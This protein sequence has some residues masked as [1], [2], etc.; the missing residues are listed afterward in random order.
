MLM[1]MSQPREDWQRLADYVISARIAAGHETTRAFARA[2]GI[3]ERTLGKLE[4]AQPVGPETLAV[5]AKTVGWTPDS[6][7]RILGRGEPEPLRPAPEP[8]PRPEFDFS[9]PEPSEAARFL[10][11]GDLT[12]QRIWDLPD[13]TEDERTAMIR[14]LDERRAR[15]RGDSG[16]RASDTA[17]GVSLTCGN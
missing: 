12:K 3:T 14:V 10:F 5:V 15:S 11:P 1:T 8:P 16:G 17:L 7:R 9:I 4:N 6:P 2:T 13:V